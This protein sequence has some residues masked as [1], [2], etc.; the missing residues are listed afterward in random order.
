MVFDCDF[1][2]I[3][4]TLNAPF[5]FLTLRYFTCITRKKKDVS[6]V[7][8]NFQRTL[9][10]QSLFLKQYVFRNYNYN[11]SHAVCTNLI[12]VFFIIYF[13]MLNLMYQ[14]LTFVVAF[15]Q[16]L[17]SFS[18]V[19]IWVLFW[20][21]CSSCLVLQIFLALH[22]SAIFILQFGNVS[23]TFLNTFLH[24]TSYTAAMIT[25]VP[26]RNFFFPNEIVFQR[27]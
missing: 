19:L 12:T 22:V 20:S 2:I 13:F 15:S 11:S 14:G 27:L 24:S 25:K 5:C 9:W 21:V 1:L 23:M 10:M 4:G 6:Q 18:F 16:L 8:G 3:N 26:N 17:V 7:T